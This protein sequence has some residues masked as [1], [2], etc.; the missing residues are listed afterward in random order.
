MWDKMWGEPEDT[1]NSLINT[2]GYSILWRTLPP[3]ITIDFI[4]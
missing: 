2:R 3:P 4:D 1:K